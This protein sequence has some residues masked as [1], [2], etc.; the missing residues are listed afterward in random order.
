MIGKI[1]RI[2]TIP[3]SLLAL[4][5][6][7][8]TGAKDG[9][10]PEMREVELHISGGTLVPTE[11]LE[12]ALKPALSTG[13]EEENP[14]QQ[15]EEKDKQN[16]RLIFEWEDE[17]KKEK[18]SSQLLEASPFDPQ[19]VFQEVMGDLVPFDK[20][21]SI[22]R[23]EALTVPELLE[24]LAEFGQFNIAIAQGLEDLI[25][26]KLN[27]ESV[28]LREVLITIL[29]RYQLKL[30]RIGD[31]LWIDRGN[32][33]GD[34][35]VFNVIRLHSIS[36]MS[37][38]EQLSEILGGAGQAPAG[39]EF[40]GGGGGSG[41]GFFTIHPDSNTIFI[42]AQP[43]ILDA[44]TKF[45]KAVDFQGRQV[46]I[47]MQILEINV[48]DTD[49]WG[50]FVT[51]LD[52]FSLNKN[53]K[54]DLV[55]DFLFKLEPGEG[56]DLLNPLGTPW[57]AERPTGIIRFMGGSE[58][59]VT[60]WLDFLQTMGSVDVLSSPRIVATNGQEAQIEI[61]DKIPYID[62]TV[63]T[64]TATTATT[65]AKFIEVGIKL[66]VTP[67]IQE[68]RYVRLS[69]NSEISEF[70]ERFQG[71]PVTNQRSTTTEVVVLDGETIIVG[72]GTKNSVL[73]NEKKIPILGDIPL[74]G[75]LF[76]N[77][78]EEH[79]KFEVLILITPQI[80]RDYRDARE[81]T[82]RYRENLETARDSFR[83]KKRED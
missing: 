61:I 45:I 20:R 39:D 4:G 40:E 42:R 51:V 48:T 52:A 80:I 11:D 37:L 68:D 76:R 23:G 6:C 46:M 43:E 81:V 31:V 62:T 15:E 16:D 30:T 58:G 83:G 72:G 73:Y 70:I 57:I 8:Q 7:A 32:R 25:I 21:I 19:I 2:G 36:A 1:Y 3:L 12:P 56:V 78:R 63:T 65:T 64:G 69:V 14:N 18:R 26:Q 53:I 10:D 66:S 75:N 17:S 13:M 74:I 59:R 77:T 5:A 38:G 82:N 22:K 47:D 28:L 34:G 27:F 41:I 50:A 54:G 67:I 60:G 79:K 49:D 29:K 24:A 55:S 33:A 9:L 71:V 44:M 35:M